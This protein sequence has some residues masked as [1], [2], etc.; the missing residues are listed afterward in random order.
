MIHALWFHLMY[1]G[2]VCV[3]LDCYSNQKYELLIYNIANFL[4]SFACCISFSFFQ[5]L[6]SAAKNTLLTSLFQAA[7][8]SYYT[9]P[10]NLSTNTKKKFNR[11][12]PHFCYCTVHCVFWFVCL[13]MPGC[14][15]V[16]QARAHE[17]FLLCVCV[18]NH[19]S[20]QLCV[21]A[22][23]VYEWGGAGWGTR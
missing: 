12:H 16:T 17:N 6:H 19:Y 1:G 3:P 22:V 23:S 4:W 10:S 11:V 20:V 14:I 15:T 13:H 5:F 8:I 18:Y 7:S 21:F 2:S 9:L